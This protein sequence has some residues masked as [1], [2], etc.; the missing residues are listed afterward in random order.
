MID[1]GEAKNQTDLARKLGISKVH[2]CRV[3]R[4]LKLNDEFIYA[5]ENI[6]NPMPTRIVTEEMLRKCLSS[7]KLYKSVLSRLSNLNE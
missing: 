5:V 6:G 4:L 7:P 2:V 3:L 1:S